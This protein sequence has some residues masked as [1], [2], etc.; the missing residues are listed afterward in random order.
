MGEW[1]KSKAALNTWGGIAETVG[2]ESV[3]GLMERNGKKKR[4]NPNYKKN[5]IT[6]NTFEHVSKYTTAWDCGKIGSY[7]E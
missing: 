7:V 3:G 1:V 5:W 2:S 4:K 6:K